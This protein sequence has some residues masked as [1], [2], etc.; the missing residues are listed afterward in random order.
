MKFLRKLKW[1]WNW[2]DW[3]WRKLGD[4]NHCEPN[5]CCCEKGCHSLEVDPFDRYPSN[6][7]YAG[8]FRIFCG[9]HKPK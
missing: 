3:H 7:D 6:S 9:D 5:W 4:K 8:A 1:Y 2:F